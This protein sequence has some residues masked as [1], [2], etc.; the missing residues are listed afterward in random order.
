MSAL[1]NIVHSIEGTDSEVS[2]LAELEREVGTDTFQEPDTHDGGT[3][4]HR[5]SPLPRV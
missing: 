3:F 2:T 5:R 4:D 1:D